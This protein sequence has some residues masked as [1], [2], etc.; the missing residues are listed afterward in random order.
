MPR[1][2]TPQICDTVILAGAGTFGEDVPCRI[3]GFH[4]IDQATDLLGA[5]RRLVP[6]HPEDPELA[7]LQCLAGYTLWARPWETTWTGTVPWSDT[8]IALFRLQWRDKVH[9]PT[10]DRHLVT[11]RAY[12]AL[13]SRFPPLSAHDRLARTAWRADTSR[14]ILARRR[15]RTVQAA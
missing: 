2:L 8:E 10:A 11:S 1:L 3:D 4:R 15:D 5:A 6:C 9:S 14:R 12:P 13:F 7:V